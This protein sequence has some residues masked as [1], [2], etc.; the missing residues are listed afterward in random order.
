MP[1]RTL[2]IDNNPDH[3]EALYSKVMFPFLYKHPEYRDFAFMSAFFVPLAIIVFMYFN[4]EEYL[5]AFGW[6]ASF[7]IFFPL[8]I[9][10]KIYD[11]SEWNQLL[12][13]FQKELMRHHTYFLKFNDE[14]LIV[15]TDLEEKIYQWSMLHACYIEEEY[16]IIEIGDRIVIPKTATE[17]NDFMAIAD[18]LTYKSNSITT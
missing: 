12:Y 16:I 4:T 2:H 14:V 8:I 11:K 18:V 17:L 13:Q 7:F 10:L 15:S 5:K 9:F 6:A 1:F 3:F